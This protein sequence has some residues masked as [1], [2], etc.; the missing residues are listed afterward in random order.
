MFVKVLHRGFGLFGCG[1]F[2][3]GTLVVTVAVCVRVETPGFFGV[4]AVRV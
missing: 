2:E 1:P 3:F 4:R